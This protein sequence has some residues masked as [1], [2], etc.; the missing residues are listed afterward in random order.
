MLGA[1]LLLASTA[2]T[3]VAAIPQGEAAETVRRIPAAE[4]RQGVAAGP[5]GIYAVAN[6]MIARYDRKTGERL[7]L[8]EGD[9]ARYPHI[10]SCAL[11]K[12]E[13]VCAA[14]NFPAV[15]HASSVEIFDP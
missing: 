6:W 1:L 14:S 11:I 4:A 9:P 13:L 8:W 2:A 10:N 12:G 5:V 15:P 3:P 7:K